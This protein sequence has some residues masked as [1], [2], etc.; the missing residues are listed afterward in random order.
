MRTS[1]RAG[2]ITS[3]SA[4]TSCTYPRASPNSGRSP[5]N[6]V[7]SGDVKMLIPWTD[8]S[9]ARS[10]SAASTGARSCSR[11]MTYTRTDA[12]TIDSATAAADPTAIRARKLTSGLAERVADAADRVDEPRRVALLRLAAEVADVDVERVR[13][14]TEVVAPHA[15]ED[16]RPRQH[17]SRVAQEELEQREFGPRELDRPSAPAHL[18]C[19][20][21]ELEIGEAQNVTALVTVPGTPQERAESS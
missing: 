21:V 9:A 18:A 8:I 10:R 20:Q 1:C 4:C 6:R 15:L 12:A 14:R 16:A 5:R 3:P 2:T 19:S 7:P 17:L 13:R 11:A